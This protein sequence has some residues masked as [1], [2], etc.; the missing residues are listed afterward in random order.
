MQKFVRAL[1]LACCAL[2]AV[3]QLHAQRGG[4]W[5]TIGSNGQRSYWVRSDA[6]IS[7]ETMRKPGFQL[8]WKIKQKSEARLL[9]SPT[10]PAL[11]DF[12]IGYRGFRSLAFVGY[13]S[14]KVIGIDV[15]LARIEWEKDLG[16]GPPPAPSMLCPGGMT[17][18][19]TRPTSVSYLAAL[20]HGFGRDAPAKSGVGEPLEGAVTLKERAIQSPPPAPVPAT[21]SKRTSTLPPDPYAPTVQY[22]HALTSDGKFHSLYVS[23]GEEPDPPIQFLPPNANALGLIV[24]DKTAYVATVNGC[25]DVE[26]GVW[27]LNLDSRKV[28][29]WKSSS[30]VGSAGFAVGPDGTLYVAAGGGVLVALEPSTLAVKSSYRSE[31]EFTASPVVFEYR[32]KDLIAVTTSDG[33][34]HLVDSAA[35][36]GPP[37][38]TTPAFSKENCL[39]GSLASWR[40][41][42]GTRWVLAP[43]TGSAVISSG[44]AVNNGEIRNG[45]IVAFEV[46]EENGLPTLRPGWSSRDML[47]PLPP[48]IVNGV[49]FAL[50]SGM[51]G[52]GDAQ[53]PAAHGVEL[54]SKAVLYALD[55]ASGKELWNSGGTISSF[56]HSGGLAAGGGRVYVGGYDGTQYAFG[57][58]MEH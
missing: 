18:S 44:S 52:S 39:V 7:V 10:P 36:A 16:S 6:K 55:G 40:D 29:H 34:M 57:F 5:M 23:N 9:N 41:S 15:D 48:T 8:I 19:V 21:A 31:K 58:P 45:T 17:S 38:S 47:S 11:F 2:S 30:V 42:N 43:V 49:V 27:A 4:D 35:L 32:G 13:S 20:G 51:I 24:F 37:L 1:S 53:M 25:S 46:V 3:S 50:S 12:Y 26:N 33:R 22:V 54:S 28:T 56:V 14:D